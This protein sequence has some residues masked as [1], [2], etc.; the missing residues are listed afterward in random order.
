MVAKAPAHLSSETRSEAL[1]AL[2]A[3]PLDVLV[4]GGGVTGAGCALDAATRGLRTGLVESR[5]WA[6]GTSSRSS[7]LMHGGLRYLE[8]LDFK[9][10]LEALHER[11]LLIK[12]TAPH[13]V[14]PVAFLYPLQQHWERA[15]VGAGIAL[16]DAMA[17]RFGHERGVPF[18]K[19]I[20]GPKLAK[21][22]PGMSPEA[23]IGAIQYWD[24]QMDDARFVQMLVRTAVQY[25]AH[26]ASRTEVIEYLREDGSVSG[27]RVRDLETGEEIDIRAKV[28]I[29]ATGVWTEANQKLAGAESGLQVRASK[30]VHFT[31]ARDKIQAVP[32]TGIISKTEKSVL[33]I[34]PWDTFWLI[35]TTDSPWN[36]AVDAPVATDTDIEYLLEHANAVLKDKLVR[37]DI[38]GVYSG[39]RPL[40]QPVAKDENATTKVSREHTV[41][42]PTPGLVSIAGGKYTTYRVMAEDAVDFAIRNTHPDRTCI[43]ETLGLAGAEGLAA[44]KNRAAEFKSAYGWDEARWQR[45]LFRYGSRVTEIADSIDDDVTLN[46][47]LGGA[48]NYL[49]AEALYAATHE[50][51]LHLDDVLERRIRLNFE[52]KDRGVSAA[53]EVADLI[54]SPLGWDAERLEREVAD[55]TRH[56]EATLAAETVATD[57][58]AVSTLRASGTY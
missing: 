36:E 22:F 12:T 37:D 57:A 8:M 28:V 46:V 7:K 33:F 13:L 16:Y 34:I 56:V 4:V 30:G 55:F 48:P 42:E 40:L 38:L 9:L 53:R 20:S 54:A 49:R 43:T 26:A 19:H 24:A 50:G 51:A 23:A 29:S 32:N 27:A 15:Y 17:T 1:R 52:T 5:D 10:V 18:H 31:V 11:D 25:G 41:M 6:S 14:R 45:L 2:A 47:P 3:K 21:V 39:L 58:E 44:V 35:G